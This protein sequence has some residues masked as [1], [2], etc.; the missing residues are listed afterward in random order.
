MEY[1]LHTERHKDGQRFGSQCTEAVDLANTE[2]HCGIQTVHLLKFQ[3]RK[4]TKVF[5]RRSQDS[6]GVVVKL[7]LCI[8]SVY[9]RQHGEHHTLVTGSQV[10]EKLFHFLL[11]L[12]HIIGNG[13]REVVV[14]VLTA[15]PIRNIGFNAEQAALRF[16][17]GFISRNRDN[18]D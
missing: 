10:I 16:S 18:V 3:G 13:S 8:R 9:H 5:S 2:R 11:L 4:L 17:H 1:V 12:F 14:G 6:F 7:F 15:L